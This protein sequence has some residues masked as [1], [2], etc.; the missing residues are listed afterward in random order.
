MITMINQIKIFAVATS[1]GLFSS[2]DM[3]TIGFGYSEGDCIEEINK[4]YV[5]KKVEAMYRIDRVDDG[6]LSLST[7]QNNQWIYLDVKDNSYF[8]EKKNFSYQQID[9]PQTQT[10]SLSRRL[11]TIDINTKKRKED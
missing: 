4:N 11:K 6:K 1:L 2:C 3:P 8:K 10:E 9:C 7:F 5:G